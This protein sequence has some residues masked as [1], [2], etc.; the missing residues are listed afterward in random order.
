MSTE[1]YHLVH[2]SLLIPRYSLL[3]PSSLFEPSCERCGFFF[4]FFP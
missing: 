3:N 1:K 4:G 2:Y